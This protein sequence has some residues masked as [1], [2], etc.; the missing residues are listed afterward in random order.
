M[1]TELAW[2]NL[3]ARQLFLRLRKRVIL[4]VIGL[5]F[6]ILCVPH[7]HTNPR[8]HGTTLFGCIAVIIDFKERLVLIAGT[9]CR[10]DEEINLHRPQFHFTCRTC[11]P[12]A[13][14]C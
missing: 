8:T 3:F 9:F 5:D 2:H 4:P 10:R 11:A 1:I 12:Y 6:T 14:L 13:L 7:F